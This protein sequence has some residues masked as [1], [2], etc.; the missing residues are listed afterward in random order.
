MNGPGLCWKV[1]YTKPHAEVWA[2][3]SLRRQS[4]V[5]LP[6]RVRGRSSFAPLPRSTRGI[7]YP[8]HCRDLVR[9]GDRPGP[10]IDR[11]PPQ[12]LSAATGGCTCLT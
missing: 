2:E 5:A 3:A 1:L 8:V 6:R 7:L 12:S 10:N 4:F 11:F 9:C